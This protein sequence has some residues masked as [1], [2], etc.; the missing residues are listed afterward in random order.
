MVDADI[1][2][3]LKHGQASEIPLIPQE[4][5]KQDYPRD[6]V[7]FMDMMLKKYHMKRKNVA[8]RAGLSQDYTYKLLNGQKK[9]NE[10]DYIL[11]ICIATGMNFSET[12]WALDIYSMPMLGSSDFRSHIISCCIRAGQD[13]DEIN[14]ILELHNFDPIKVSPDMKSS[15]FRRIKDNRTPAESGIDISDYE[16]IS[17]MIE[18]E[19]CGNAPMDYSF[20]GVLKISNGKTAYYVEAAYS[21]F[22]DQFD[23]MTEEMH[24]LFE[25]K[26]KEYNQVI[27]TDIDDLDVLNLSDPSE[28]IEVVEHYESL[29]EAARSPF[30]KWYLELDRAVD[31]KVLK[32]LNS[33]DDTRNNEPRFGAKLGD[34]N[35]I[36]YMEAFNTEEPEKR[37]YF[38]IIKDGDDYTYSISHESY[39]MKIELGSIY[40]IYFKEKSHPEEYFIKVHDLAELKGNS[41]RYGVIFKHLRLYLHQFIHQNFD[42]ESSVSD[43]TLV[44]DQLE[45]LLR[46]AA[47]C[48]RSGDVEG[49]AELNRTA[50]DLMKT[51]NDDMLAGKIV[52]AYKL[53]CCFD[54][55]GKLE[56][57]KYWEEECLSYKDILKAQIAS[58]QNKQIFGSAP[59]TIA[60]ILNKKG[61]DLY[62]AGDIQSCLNIMEEAI[63]FFEGTCCDSDDWGQY[64][65]C[66]INYSAATEEV[67]MQKALELLED[68]LTIIEDHDLEKDSDSQHLIFLL[69]NNLAWVLWN[70]FSSEEAI[71]YYSKAI[72]VIERRLRNDKND[73]VLSISE[74]EKEVGRLYEIYMSTSKD[75][76]AER[77]KKKYAKKGITIE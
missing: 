51:S 64:A 3:L 44:E 22:G 31:D 63:S 5:Q 68:A 72:D 56:D 66:L 12:Q 50:Y 15:E 35:W 19:K 46:Q 10:R 1:L 37:E 49:S 67:D 75:R 53:S 29:I 11:A 13:I 48:M 24:D 69:Y 71:I 43:D 58:A 33:V 47:M 18:A 73:P 76:E 57:S 41:A 38:Q 45:V 30:F 4:L 74:L 23:V 36:Y 54:Q 77:L 42:F 25:K 8:Q 55:L 52:T 27:E 59:V 34:K 70:E 62:K 16:E 65:N 7:V 28:G 32:T 21:E 26:A 39:F 9:T 17:R 40:E 20:W 60:I 6:F 14:D 2:Y 61:R